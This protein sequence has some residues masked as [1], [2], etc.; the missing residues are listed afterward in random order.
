MELSE[1]DKSV[2]G[3]IGVYN[4]SVVV[5]LEDN[6]HRSAAPL[7]WNDNVTAIA[8]KFE[9]LILSCLAICPY[10]PLS[11]YWRSGSEKTLWQQLC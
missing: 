4:T 3:N 11:G 9:N 8:G 7:F 10:V 1:G 2:A 6:M 5:F